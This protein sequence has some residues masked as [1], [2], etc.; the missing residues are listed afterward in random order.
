MGLI[1]HRQTIISS[2]KYMITFSTGSKPGIS[3]APLFTRPLEA[4]GW[5]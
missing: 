1:Y 2:Q 3:G 5:R 4:A